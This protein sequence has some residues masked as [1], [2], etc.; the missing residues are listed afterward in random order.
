ML[1]N[2]KN[3]DTWKIKANNQTIRQKKQISPIVIEKYLTFA[4]VKPTI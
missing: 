1:L 3:E 4:V 2:A